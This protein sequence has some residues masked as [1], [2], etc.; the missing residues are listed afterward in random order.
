[1]VRNHARRFL[2]AVLAVMTLCSMFTFTA[3]A[4]SNLAVIYYKGY[5][6]P[7]IHY[8]TSN[9]SWTTAPGLKMEKNNEAEGYTHKYTIDLGSKTSTKLCFN[10]GNGAWDNNGGK[11]HT[12][13][14]GN[15]Y[16][17]TSGTFVSTLKADVT[18]DKAVANTNETINF[19]TTAS[20]GYTTYQYKYAFT[21]LDTKEVSETSY[22]DSKTYSKSFTVAGSYQAKVSVKDYS[23][24]VVTDTVNFTVESKEFK[25]TSFEVTPVKN[26]GLYEFANMKVT[27]TGGSGQYFYKYTYSIY[28]QEPYNL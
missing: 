22:S 5:T 13:V 8:Q 25:V 7:Y 11:D 3:N 1:M 16:Y 12:A 2:A 28:G 4:A 26:V 18:A 24:K 6:S 9:G 14:A 20:G 15:N 19:T 27:A 21:N 23:G 17:V 10:N